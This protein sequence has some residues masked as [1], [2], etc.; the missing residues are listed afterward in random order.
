MARSDVRSGLFEDDAAIRRVHGE[1]VLLLGGGRALLMQIA[2]PLVARAV[3]EHS[4]YQHDRWGRLLR[5]VRP[6]YAIIFGTADQAEAAATRVNRLHESVR[7]DG[8]RAMDPRLLAWV[9]ATL[10]DT[11]LLT[12]ERF[13]RSLAPAE[14]AAY[15]QDARAAGM[16][17]G[18]PRNALPGDIAGFRRYVDDQVA[19][20]EVTDAARAIARDLFEPLPGTGPAMVLMRQLT[21]A[22]LPPRLR[23]AY[24][25]RSGPAQ[26]AA[27]EVTGAINRA[28]SAVLPPRLRRPPGFL[29]PPNGHTR[30]QVTVSG[31]PSRQSGQSPG[32]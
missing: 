1:A 16:L 22:L 26:R 14:V 20:I 30:G 7:G 3:S 32:S 29:L 21:A 23:E 24:G 27:L 4:S 25:L 13:V 17:L 15:Y 8:Y 2:H 18:V 6:M 11:S 31:T 28:A 12:Y 5:T 19:S 10:I 9:L